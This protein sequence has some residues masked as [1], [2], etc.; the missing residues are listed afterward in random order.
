MR[1]GADKYIT[2]PFADT[3]LIESIEEVLTA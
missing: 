2:K 3:G 1:A